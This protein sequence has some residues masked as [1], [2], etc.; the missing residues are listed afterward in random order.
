VDRAVLTRC[1]V[2]LMALCAT[3]CS[4][5][6][7][8]R[9]KAARNIPGI[10]TTC[11]VAA[12]FEV[13]PL[14]EVEPETTELL[15]TYLVEALNDAGLRVIAPDE[16]MPFFSAEPHASDAARAQRIAFAADREFSCN[17]IALGRL[18]RFRN[19]SGEAMGSTHPA[20]VAFD[21]QFFGAP[22]GQTLWRG[23]FDETQKALT[24][25]FLRARRYP[26]GGTRWL[27]A[28]EFARWGLGEVVSGA[29]LSARDTQ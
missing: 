8:G 10:P 29:P 21:V 27:S 7:L 1:L 20:S 9:G 18:D 28:N 14:L 17:V 2:A 22:G 16:A 19:R 25:N 6:A 13:S 11:V 24:E 3:A 23:R 26:G 15:G 5:A 4:S 12:P